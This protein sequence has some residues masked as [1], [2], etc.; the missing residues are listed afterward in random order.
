MGRLTLKPY[1][2]GSSLAHRKQSPPASPSPLSGCR[3]FFLR[4]VMLTRL[5]ILALLLAVPAAQA[6]DFLLTAEGLDRYE[7]ATE[8]FYAW[9]VMHPDLSLQADGERL[10]AMTDEE[11][12]A[13]IAAVAPEL[14][15]TLEERGIA[16]AEYHAFSRTLAA[17]ASWLTL[18]EYASFDP[19]RLSPLERENLEF[20]RGN[21]ARF[22]EFHP[23]MTPL[24]LAPQPV[25]EVFARRDGQRPDVG[26]GG[27]NQPGGEGIGMEIQRQA[28][29]PVLRVA[30]VPGDAI[31]AAILVAMIVLETHAGVAARQHPGARA[32]FAD[33]KGNADFTLAAG[34][35]VR[36]HALRGEVLVGGLGA[37]GHPSFE[38]LPAIRFDCLPERLARRV[39]A[40]RKQYQHHRPH[41]D[42]S[43]SGKG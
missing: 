22:I 37:A 16:L 1:T 6:E 27:G 20:V 24:L 34:S 19:S 11:F 26:R 39:H 8:I 29:V 43:P 3:R 17:Y 10:G 7:Q 14:L 30:A 2:T 13:Q 32:V 40:A 9:A 31:L 25:G 5:A 36:H 12:R 33:M 42:H 15:E 21:R 41:R 23:E 35:D 4:H 38:G 28:I 18:M